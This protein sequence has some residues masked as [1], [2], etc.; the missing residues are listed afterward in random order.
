MSHHQEN[1]S[2]GL[3]VIS[4]LAGAVTGAAVALL[5]APQSGRETREKLAGYSE[6]LR[7]K[8][9]H[10]PDEV[11]EHAGSAVDRGKAM[12]EQ[13]RELIE[14]GNKLAG[15]GKDYLDQKRKT[16]SAAIEAGRQAMA[17]EKEALDRTLEE[18]E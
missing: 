8:C 10:F 4:F 13:G 17:E 6:E 7:E 11:K 12:I 2:A 9:R 1:C 16:L 18:K 5:L 15:Q 3:T 14:R